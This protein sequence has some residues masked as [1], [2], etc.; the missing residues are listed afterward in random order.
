MANFPASLPSLPDAG[1]LVGVEL[2]GD[3]DPTKVHS[4]VH[5]NAND[6]IEAIAT[7]V[8]IHRYNGLSGDRGLWVPRDW[9]AN[10]R[11]ARNAHAASPA[12][13]VAWGDS[14]TQ[15]FYSSDFTPPGTS[16]FAKVVGDLQS[17]YSDGGSG[18]QSVINSSVLGVAGANYVTLTGSWTLQAATM[19]EA[20]IFP[21]SAGVGT[22]T[23]PAVR[24]TSIDIHYVQTTVPGVQFSYAIDGGAP[25]VFTCGGQAS[26]DLRTLAITGLG[27]GSHSVVLTA[28]TGNPILVGVTGKNATGIIAD[29]MGFAGRFA[30][31]GTGTTWLTGG[32]TAQQVSISDRNPDLFIVSLGLNDASGA[33]A[34]TVY[35]TAISRFLYGVRFNDPDVDMLIITQ[36]EGN[37]L[38]TGYFFSQYAGLVRGIAETYNCALYDAWQHGK[39]SWDYWNGLGN[40]GV[41]GGSGG[42]AGTDLIH[43]SNAGYAAMAGPIY[44][45][46]AAA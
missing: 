29:N 1:A 4:T 31:A 23:F 41:T 9:G 34:I 2:D 6:E 5:G 3:G 10:W 32:K 8:G 40:W 35:M 16:W 13:I 21:A 11:T 28:T 38:D 42:G 26:V 30:T 37:L 7:K 43:P 12:K 25:T 17:A 27:A 22:V 44:D 46:L 24:G 19:N 36:H 39:N 45:L 20:A 15:G 14:I 33:E 18:F